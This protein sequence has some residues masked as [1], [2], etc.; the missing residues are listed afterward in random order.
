M[1]KTLL[2]IKIYTIFN[3][4]QIIPFYVRNFFYVSSSVVVSFST[5]TSANFFL[6]FLSPNIPTMIERFSSECHKTKTK[7]ITSTNHKKRKQ[8]NGPIRIRSKLN[9]WNRRQ[10]R[11]NTCERGTIGFGFASHWLRK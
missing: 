10:A 3:W 2:N 6:I 9:T 11:E 1:M 7:G 5:K 4:F 8:H